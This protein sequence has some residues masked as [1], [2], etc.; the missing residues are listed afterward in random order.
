MLLRPSTLP[1]RV[2]TRRHVTTMA[3]GVASWAATPAAE[4]V[5]VARDVM[6]TVFGERG[7]KPLSPS[8][9]RYLW[10]DAHGVL[11]FISLARETGDASY[12]DKADALVE[13]VH[14]TLGRTRD[15]K[16]ALPTLRIG[17]ESAEDDG[18]YF[19]YLTK[20][21]LALN[22]LS[23]AR[24]DPSYNER[25]LHLA[26]RTHRAFVYET[27][28]G[29]LHSYWKM[30]MDM[31]RPL[32]PSE[33]NLD[34]FD[35]LSVYTLIKESAPPEQQAL[36]ANEVRDMESMVQRKLALG[37]FVSTD[38]LDLG[39]AL[40]TAAWH[41][42]Q[43]WARVLADRALAAL[44]V[45]WQRGSFEEADRHRLA[46]REFGTTIGVQVHPSSRDAWR[47][48]VRALHAHWQRSLYGRD[49]DIT[50]A[51]FASSLLPGAFSRAYDDLPPVPRAPPAQAK[52]E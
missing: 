21:C 18:T 27:P 14:D 13:A 8:M 4:A 30:N 11:N 24:G 44:E 15:G 42:A 25:A 19:H 17:K 34:A 23:L 46:F 50:P 22:R 28:G 20:W 35:A 26:K 3:A 29:T 6:R 45:L 31:S 36:L 12:L 52:E 37:G 10:T 40:Q 41:P 9:S 32:V 5:P 39:E 2:A 16:R 1:R 38:A 43:P 33:G 49:R 48:R 47:P 51:M 7:D